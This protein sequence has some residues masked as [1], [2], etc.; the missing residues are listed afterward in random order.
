MTITVE[1]GTN[2]PDANSYV[3]VEEL[4]A[5][6]ADRGIVL[7]ADDAAKEVLLI[8][9]MDYLEMADHDFMGVR[10]FTDQP[11]SWPR[12]SYSMDLGIPK[13]L[14]KA[15]MV[16]AVAAMTVDLTPVSRGLAGKKVKVGPIEVEK[17]GESV[18]RPRVPQA[19]S[20]LRYLYGSSIGAGQ[21]RVVRA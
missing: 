11:L 5:Y 21:L 1:D 14:K 7:P 19:E 6:A 9:A 3:S 8:K 10:S 18:A 13:E 4:T 16:L 20:L 2:V 15:Q 12:I 17:P